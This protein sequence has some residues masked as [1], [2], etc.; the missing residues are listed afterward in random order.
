M[1]RVT[2]KRVHD[3]SVELRVDGAL[4]EEALSLLVDVCSRYLDLG[5]RVVLDMAGVT[6][7][8]RT[9]GQRLRALKDRVSVVNAPSYL[10][11]LLQVYK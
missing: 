5:L 11:L 4:E 6:Y 10:N 2:E 8:D 1:V 9:A 3:L 7:A